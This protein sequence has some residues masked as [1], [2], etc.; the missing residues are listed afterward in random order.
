MELEFNNA[1]IRKGFANRIIVSIIPA[2][3]VVVVFRALVFFPGI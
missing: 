2:I 3:P 1:Q